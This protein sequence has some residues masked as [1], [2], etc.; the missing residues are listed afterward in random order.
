MRAR[1]GRGSTLRAVDLSG[2]RWRSTG[3]VVGGGLGGGWPG[4]CAAN[5]RPSQGA[6]LRPSQGKCGECTENYILKY[7]IWTFSPQ[8]Y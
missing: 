8:N 4:R 1:F 5:F 7:F 2:G 6:N 3:S